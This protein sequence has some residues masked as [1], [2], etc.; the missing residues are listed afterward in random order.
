MKIT[1]VTRDYPPK[2]GGVATYAYQVAKHLQDLGAE[3][4]MVVRGGD[5]RTLW[6]ASREKPVGQEV[7]HVLSAPYGAF[8]QRDRLIV[9]VHEPV[10]DELT[11]YP[12]LRRIKGL[13]AVRLEKRA[14]RKARRVIA[15][16]NCF[17]RRLEES[18][19][20][21]SL[22]R[23]VSHAPDPRLLEGAVKPEGGKMK[24]LISARLEARKNIP[25]AFKDV[26]L[27]VH[28]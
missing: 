1:L 19:V 25:E 20:D 28:N 8:A 10:S 23:V 14:L 24:V 27:V 5:I 16:S 26:L 9:T 15:V 13:M 22:I 3:V 11:Y 12:F 7:L 6:A 2:I 4:R 21:G 18:E 17:A